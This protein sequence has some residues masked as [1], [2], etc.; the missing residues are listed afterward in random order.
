MV[1]TVLA[2]RWTRALDLNDDK[3]IHTIMYQLEKIFRRC[4]KK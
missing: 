4:E 2:N 3:K 1:D